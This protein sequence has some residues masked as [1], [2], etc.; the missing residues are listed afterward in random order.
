MKS[1]WIY[2]KGTR[3]STSLKTS[4]HSIC[5]RHGGF[6]E[7]LVSSWQLSFAICHRKYNLSVFV[8]YQ[9]FFCIQS[10]GI[11]FWY[12][13]CLVTSFPNS[14]RDQLEV[15]RDSW[16]YLFAKLMNFRL[17]CRWT[18]TTFNHCSKRHY[19]PFEWFSKSSR[20]T[21]SHRPRDLGHFADSNSI[22]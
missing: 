14:S 17:I 12:A 15:Q 2:Q 5:S 8:G 18:W 11:N 1:P 9:D 7:F 16:Q 4:L 3:T 21:F 13:C 19:W 10:S 22:P 20:M 6:S